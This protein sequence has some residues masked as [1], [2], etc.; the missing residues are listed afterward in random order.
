MKVS[1]RVVADVVKSALK[2]ADSAGHG[3]ASRGAALGAAGGALLGSFWG[4]FGAPLGG[5]IG[6]FLGFHVDAAYDLDSGRGGYDV[7]L[8]KGD[9]VTVSRGLYSHC[10]VVYAGSG[11]RV[12]VV[13]NSPEEGVAVRSLTAFAKG[14]EVRITHR[15]A[16]REVPAILERARD[17][18]GER[19]D[20]L[21]YNCEH[22]V[23]EVLDREVESPQLRQW[24]GVV[25]GLGLGLVGLGWLGSPSST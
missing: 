14:G 18:C 9:V 22:F 25:V 5:A 3:G 7:E 6:G 20:W 11:R 17:L 4:R 8:R 16:S 23:N 15:P 24:G 10:G 12:K 1:G 13:D 2:E 21:L 19:Y